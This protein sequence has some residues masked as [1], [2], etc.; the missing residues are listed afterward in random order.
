MSEVNRNIRP[1]YSI[2]CTIRD[3]DEDIDLSQ[4]LMNVVLVSSINSP[5]QTVITSFLV[6]SKLLVRKDLFGKNDMELEIQLMSDGVSPTENIKLTLITIRQDAPLSLKT[7]NS[8]GLDVQDMLTVVNVIKKPYIQMSTLVNILFDE[9]H[10]KTP[11]EL[12]EETISE[13]LPT[14]TTDIIDTNSNEERLF[15]FIIPPMNFM[16]SIRYI[17]GSNMDLVDK[18]GPGVGIFNGPMFFTNRFEKEGENTFCMWDLG[19]KSSGDIEYTIY[20]LALG[21]DDSDIMEKAG[22][23][24][25]VFYTRNDINHIYRG[26]QDVS[27][28]YYKNKFL[29][30]PIDNFYSEIELTMDDVFDYSIHDGG[31]LNINESLKDLYTYRNN[32]EVGLET[33]SIPYIARLSRKIS[34]LSEIEIYIDRNLSIDKLSR[35]G[36][37]MDLKPRTSDYIDIG[38]KYIVNSSRISFGRETD[39]WV[40]R[41]RIKAARGNLKTI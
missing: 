21:D 10:R 11:I 28:N 38:G 32:L 8:I 22:N 30:K 13:F 27:I 29:S 12:V 41:A 26:N 33:S 18:Y 9:S 15:Q 1:Y 24:D 3:E 5:Y 7:A 23:E 34:S 25:D 2:T 20:Q 36:V 31:S 14:M 17:D 4:N 6:D 37:T 16:D 19:S 35:V 39:S 40:C